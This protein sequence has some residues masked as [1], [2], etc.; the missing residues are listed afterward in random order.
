MAQLQAI[1]SSI[2]RDVLAAQHEANLYSL[3]LS[4]SYRKEGQT[5]AFPLPSIAVGEMELDIYYGIKDVGTQAEQYEVNY[6]LLRKN[7]KNISFQLA[8]VILDK[9][10]MSVLSSPLGKDKEQVSIISKIKEQP[11]LNRSLIGFLER[12][13][14]AQITSQFTKLLKK[15]GGINEEVLGSCAVDIGVNELLYHSELFSLFTSSEGEAV[16][17][18]ASGDMK[19][20]ISDYI[21]KLVKDLDFR[22]KRIVPSVDVIVAADELSKLPEECIHKFHFK[23]SP[24]SLSLNLADVEEE[25][26]L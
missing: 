25:N 15:N 21:P 7:L 19:K 17:Q 11:E 12:K 23:V 8:K 18:K 4:E 5:E 6:P 10:I 26:E 2:L 20:G 9:V 22:R 14:L 24:R 3:Y 13:L 1:I 16:R